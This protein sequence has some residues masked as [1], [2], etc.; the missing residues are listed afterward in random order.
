[1]KRKIKQITLSETHAA[2]LEVSFQ[3]LINEAI[4]DLAKNHPNP[5]KIEIIT[6]FGDSLQGMTSCN[7]SVDDFIHTLEKDETVDDV[8][9]IFTSHGNGKF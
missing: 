8:E 1:M 2:V 6:D 5:P 3:I 4:S 7:A 9:I